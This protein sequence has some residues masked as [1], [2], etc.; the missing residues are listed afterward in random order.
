MGSHQADT[1]N[2]I[3]LPNEK[4]IIKKLGPIVELPSDL[5]QKMDAS[6]DVLDAVVCLLAARDFLLGEAMRPIDRNLA[7]IE[8]WIW[9]RD[10]ALALRAKA[11][12]KRH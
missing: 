1:R 7:E 10:P 9:T 11:E 4:E 12:A 3:R 2:P 6:A 5:L 8:G